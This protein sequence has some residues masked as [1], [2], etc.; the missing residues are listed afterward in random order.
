MD[1]FDKIEKMLSVI[2]NGVFHIYNTRKYRE[3]IISTNFNIEDI[4]K[5][6]IVFSDGDYKYSSNM[7][8]HY[9]I[10]LSIIL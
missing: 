6:Y 5:K 3:Y 7:Y 10:Y 1:T 9:Y 4:A 8:Y 2:I